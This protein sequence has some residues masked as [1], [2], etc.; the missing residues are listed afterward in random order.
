MLESRGS[1]SRSGRIS[2]IIVDGLR[3]PSA[4]VLQVLYTP[5]GNIKMKRLNSETHE[6][7]KSGREC[8]LWNIK[9]L[10]PAW[11]ELE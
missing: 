7:P 2:K 10:K 4:M 5:D 6:N 11:P 1:Y 3:R 8:E 9:M